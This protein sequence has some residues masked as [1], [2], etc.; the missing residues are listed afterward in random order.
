MFKILAPILLLFVCFFPAHANTIEAGKPLPPMPPKYPGV[1][2]DAAHEY[3]IR[4]RLYELEKL[5]KKAQVQSMD[6]STANVK[7]TG[8]YDYPEFDKDGKA[9]TK[10]KAIT[11]KIK[12]P[13]SVSKTAKTLGKGVGTNL[14]GIALYELLGEAVDYVLDPANNSVR[15]TVPNTDGKWCL[16]SKSQGM[17]VFTGTHDEALYN[18][19]W[20]YQKGVD[21]M[22]FV[23]S[24]IMSSYDHKANGKPYKEY[25]YPRIIVQLEPQEEEISLDTIA[26]KIIEMAE[27]Q[28]ALAQ[29]LLKKIAD[30]RVKSGEFDDDIIANAVDNDQ[31]QDD[32]DNVSKPDTGNQTGD[33]DQTK[34]DDKDQDK[35]KDQ[36]KPDGGFKLPEF[37]DWAKWFCEDD[38]PKKQDGELDIEDSDIPKNTVNINFGGSCPAPQTFGFS[39]AG[40]PMAF[41]LSYDPICRIAIA[42]GGI[43]K[44]LSTI[45]A[46]YILAGAK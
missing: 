18:P 44:V 20:G 5:A 1:T 21:K 14:I 2:K 32:I 36:T 22:N 42:F 27:N 39:I 24:G 28:N 11:S 26:S 38:T 6:G 10:T 34:P 31:L 13:A 43:V 9:T 45:V 30:E 4:R 37:C 29:E 41:V 33:K 3:R 23:S 35:N 16:Y 46:V 15:Y 8:S 40:R 25:D 7:S 19:A 17:C 12:V